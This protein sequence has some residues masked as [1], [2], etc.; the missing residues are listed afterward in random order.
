MDRYSSSGKIQQTSEQNKIYIVLIGSAPMASLDALMISLERFKNML[1]SDSA[2][3]QFETTIRSIQPNLPAV[4]TFIDKVYA[5]K[6][7]TQA[8]TMAGRTLIIEINL[9]KNDF[10]DCIHDYDIDEILKN[11]TAV[12]TIPAK[13]DMNQKTREY[14][15]FSISYKKGKFTKI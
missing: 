9:S 8:V 14:T 6:N 4:H 5:N 11:V 12:G 2:Q 10:L 3:D 1:T 15:T 13:K 7:P